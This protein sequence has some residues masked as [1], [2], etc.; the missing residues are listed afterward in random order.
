M[1]PVTKKKGKANSIRNASKDTASTWVSLNAIFTITAFVENRME[2]RRI[3]IYPLKLE[4]VEF[5][6]CEGKIIHFF[7]KKMVNFHYN[8]CIQLIESTR[9]IWYLYSFINKPARVVKLVYTY[10]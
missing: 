5:D 4:V 1:I 10:V 9:V 6:I 3:N 7:I 2:P 8:Y